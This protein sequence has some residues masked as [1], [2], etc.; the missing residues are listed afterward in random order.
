M[1]KTAMML[2]AATVVGVTASLSPLP[3]G[4][5]GIEQSAYGVSLIALSSDDYTKHGVN[6][7]ERADFDNDN[8]LD[9]NEFSTLMVVQAELARLNG[10]VPIETAEKA[11]TISTS[12]GSAGAHVHGQDSFSGLS[13]AERI[14]IDAVSRLQFYEGAGSDE[15]LTKTEFINLEQKG[16]KDAD[17]NG[18]GSLTGRELIKFARAKAAYLEADV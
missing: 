3:D 18:S 10:F 9:V 13:R 12:S 7:F 1:I 8:T 11:G 6:I 15:L 14:R 2:L 16:F 4:Q 5:D 17:V